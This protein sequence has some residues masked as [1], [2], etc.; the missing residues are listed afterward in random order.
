MLIS[1]CIPSYNRPAQLNKLLNSIDCSPGFVE[2]VVA[3]DNSPNRAL[4]SEVVRCFS[5]ESDYNVIYHENKVNLGYDANL[6]NL[7]RL[8]SGKFVMFIGDDDW[9]VEGALEQFVSFLQFHLDCGYVLRSYYQQHPNGTLE[10]FKYFKDEKVFYPSV[11]TAA[12]LFKRTV[13]IAGVTFNRELALQLESDHYD[14]TLLYQLYLVLEI[15]FKHNT[16]YCDIPVA[17]MAQ[18]YRDDK[19]MFGSAAKESRFVPGKI[20]PDNSVVFTEGF[21]EIANSFDK[22]HGTDVSKLIRKDLSR[23][24]YPFLS[25]QRKRGWMEF[26]KFSV[27]LAVRTKINATWHYYFYLFALLVFGEKICD[28]VI[29]YIKQKIGFTPH[30]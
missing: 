8:A 16:V 3:E 15:A 7:I 28:S 9:F 13:S 25:I 20:T 22:N 21:F 23:Y 24:S 26:L 18:S 11:E 17:I 14:G 1:I 29:I 5:E 2:I 27:R 12:F 4:I 19:P 10:S 30:L 6:R